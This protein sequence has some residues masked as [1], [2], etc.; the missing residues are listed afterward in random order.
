[1][2]MAWLTFNIEVDMDFR[3]TEL[4]VDM[5]LRMTRIGF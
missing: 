1:M 2:E 3:L 5:D 4:E